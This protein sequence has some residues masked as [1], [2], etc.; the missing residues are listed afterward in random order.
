MDSA[1]S[2]TY[3]Q[4]DL[5]PAYRSSVPFP[6]VCFME[7]ASGTS[8]PLDARSLRFGRYNLA[9]ACELRSTGR[10]SHAP[11]KEIRID[12]RKRSL[13]P[14]PNADVWRSMYSIK[15]ATT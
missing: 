3:L 5:H 15:Q 7:G 1:Q 14:P 13:K 10:Y 2:A 8:F 6:P 12:Q 4:F 11:Q 9:Y